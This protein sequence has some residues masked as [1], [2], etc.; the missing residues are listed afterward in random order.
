MEAERPAAV[1]LAQDEFTRTPISGKGRISMKLKEWI[2]IW[3]E[4]YD[5]PL[6]RPDTQEI[7]RY[8]LKTTFFPIRVNESRTS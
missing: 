3:Q 2:P 5:A 1:Q 6:V 7:H 4:H 8:L